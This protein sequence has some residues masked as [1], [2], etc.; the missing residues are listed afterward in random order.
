[1]AGT[2]RGRKKAVSKTAEKLAKALTFVSN[3]TTD[4]KEAY[5]EHGRIING[6]LVTFNGTIAAG[7]PVDEE[8]QL[9]PHI[10]NLVT[11][12][13]KSGKSLTMSEPD[14]G[15]LTIKGDNIRATVP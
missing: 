8:L 4:G 11:A 9:C 1:M 6:Y 15:N 12:I 2:T 13:N 10:G 7:H 5:K 14:M 3:A